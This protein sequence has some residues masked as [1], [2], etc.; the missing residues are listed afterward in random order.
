[1]Y[2]RKGEIRAFMYGWIEIMYE[3]D[4]KGKLGIEGK[5]LLSF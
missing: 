3:R 5:G 2:G 4:G 1:M